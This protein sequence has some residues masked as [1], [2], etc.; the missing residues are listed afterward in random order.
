MN[1]EILN[2][3]IDNIYKDHAPFTSI[4]F[5]VGSACHCQV[6]DNETRK[7]SLTPDKQQE[8]PVFLQNLKT[9]R[10][11]DPLHIFLIDPS[12]E[13]HPYMVCD[14]VNSSEDWNANDLLNPGWICNGDVYHNQE[15]NIH[16]YCIK[17]CV[18]YPEDHF[19][20][21][22][23]EGTPKQ[24]DLE[25]ILNKIHIYAIKENWFFVFHDYS[26]RNIEQLALHYDSFIGMHKSHIIYGLGARED[27]GCYI[28]LTKPACDF[29]YSFDD[30]SVKVFNP[31]LF[32]DNIYDLKNHLDM[33]QHFFSNRDY[34]CA[35]DQSKM[36]IKNK[37]K[38]ITH[39]VDIFRRIKILCSDNEINFSE[40]DYKDIKNKY[41]IPFETYIEIKQYDELFNVMKFILNQ[42]LLY[43]F[44]IFYKNSNEIVD[45]LFN[46]IIQEKDPYKWTNIFKLTCEQC[47]IDTDM[48]QLF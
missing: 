5:A 12:L 40:Y 15:S 39:Y 19:A 7:W 45:I 42:E 31:Y 35:L 43:F 37:K 26:G 2:S 27:G 34:M 48:I 20:Y 28:D 29:L 36:F 1:K 46:M 44:N 16:V 3:Y 4:Y 41:K 25:Q 21:Y 18:T 23:H 14:D 17:E 6:Y 11:F 33:I 8:F 32:E 13:K 24:L 47:I 9:Q 10:P 22:H 30:N 38:K